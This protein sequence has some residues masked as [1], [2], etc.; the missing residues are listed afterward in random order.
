MLAPQ[1]KQN[2][3]IPW[4]LI[5]LAIHFSTAGL[6]L[7]FNQHELESSFVSVVNS[8][9]DLTSLILTFINFVRGFA[10]RNFIWK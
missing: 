4:L 6:M 7:N 2:T 1:P 5:V 3:F 9:L 10:T 8:H